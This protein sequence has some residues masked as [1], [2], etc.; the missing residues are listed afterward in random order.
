LILHALKTRFFD[1]HGLGSKR[2][3]KKLIKQL[4]SINPD[5]ILLH[6]L[7][8]YYINIQVLFEYLSQIST[9]IV[10]VFHDCW[11]FTGHCTHYD[12]VGCE[13]W[14]NECSKCP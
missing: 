1:A 8:G 9:P 6:H 13:K 11:S 2:A 3:T 7:H 12:F 10:W 14:K 4:K 5:V